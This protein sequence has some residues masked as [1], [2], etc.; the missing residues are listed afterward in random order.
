[1][2]GAALRGIPVG[3]H[4]VDGDHGLRAQAATVFR[5]SVRRAKLAS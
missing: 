5:T 1:M 2:D 3:R 4:L